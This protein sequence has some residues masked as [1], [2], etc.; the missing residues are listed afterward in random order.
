MGNLDV[1]GIDSWLCDREI[2]IRAVEVTDL[3]G[4]AGSANGLSGGGGDGDFGQRRQGGPHGPAESKG[5]A[6]L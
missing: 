2:V 5:V 1:D 3:V 6:G 4:P